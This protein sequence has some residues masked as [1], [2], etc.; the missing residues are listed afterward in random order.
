ME[1]IGIGLRELLNML[2]ASSMQPTLL[3]FWMGSR[4]CH[5][6]L[7]CTIRPLKNNIMRAT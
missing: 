5:G 7:K 3:V 2:E 4:G 6:F 1:E